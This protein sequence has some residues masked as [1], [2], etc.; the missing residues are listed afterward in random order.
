MLRDMRQNDRDIGVT[1][2]TGSMNGEGSAVGPQ[3]LSPAL[4]PRVHI[5]SFGCQMN[6]YDATRMIDLLAP[7]GYEESQ[8][9]AD[10]D[11][12]IL[13]TCHIRELAD[14]KLFSELGRLR[15]LKQ[16]RA[17]AGTAPLLAVAGCVA[18][19][20]GQEI[21][22]RQSAVD[23]VVGPQAYHRLPQLVARARARS[24]VVDTEFPV[25][26]K[27]AHLPAPAAQKTRDRGVSAFITIQEGCDKFCTFCVVP[28]TRGAEH[29][30]S[31]V[32]I[33]EEAR[34]LTDA[35]V[36]EITLLGQNVNAWQGPDERGRLH[37]LAQLL[38]ALAALPGLVRLRYMTSHPND[39]SDDLVAAHRDLP[40]LMPFLHL[41]VQSGS[42][43]ILAAMNRRHT[44]D[45]YRQR[46][47][48]L[49]AVQPAMAFSS[50]FIVGFPGESDEDF[51]DTLRLVDDIGY[52]STFFFKYSPRPGT[53][54]ADSVWPGW[55]HGS[56][57]SATRSTARKSALLS[58]FWWKNRDA[59]LAR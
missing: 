40:A 2:G 16:E 44:A 38:E 10:A 58:M 22:R 45:D 17:A 29:S 55:R 7:E 3:T 52:A 25:E 1:V 59:I 30:R 26:D 13:N 51:E 8:S 20:Q 46:V 28:Y 5:R 57:R 39:M 15:V 42:D 12:I 35:G 33:M 32:E 4:R 48:Q 41:P 24:G 14:D 19:A 9:A 11:V 47:A 27:F 31:V 53:P 54:G 23:L 43:R 21:L 6:V 49:R 18:Q 37:G 34:R 36:R 50:D 56:R